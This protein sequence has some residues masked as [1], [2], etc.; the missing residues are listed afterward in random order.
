MRLP[1]SLSLLLLAGEAMAQGPLPTLEIGAGV[2]ALNTPDYRGSANSS[3]Y[4]LPI[5]YIKYRGDRLRVDDGAKGIIFE[6]K[7]LL[8]TLSA[9]LSLPADDDTREREGM[10]EL[11]AILEIGPALNYRFYQM[12]HS[13]LW[14]DLPLRYAYTLDSDFEHVGEVFQPRLSWRKPA[15]RLGEWK[16]RFGIGPLFAS[17]EYHAYIYSVDSADATSSRP[18]YEADGGFS[19]F[20]SEFTYSKRIG[21][22]WLGG[23]IRY[24][25]LNGAVIDDSPLVSE[26]ESWMGGIALAWVFHQR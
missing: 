4:L 5:P 15:T 17:K 26:T 21:K 14:I 13:A 11:D 10:D 24:D 19:G 16:F 2:L 8:F 22:Y 7:E 23:F 9:N 1:L 25:N 20:R 6:S 18:A 3:S 12:Q